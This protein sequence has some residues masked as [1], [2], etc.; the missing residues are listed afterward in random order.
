MTMAF[1]GKGL[2]WHPPNKAQTLCHVC[3][4][5]GC[6]P[7]VCNP[8][9]TQKVDDRLNKLYSRFNAGPRR[10]RQDSH[11]SRENSNSRSRSNNNTN[12]SRPNTS[13]SSNRTNNN[14]NNHRNNNNPSGSTSPSHKPHPVSSVPPTFPS[15]NPACTLPQHNYH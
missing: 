8:C 7:S 5:P 2:T 4:R 14:N 3:G 9:T 13:Q 15:D 12:T 6:S 1:R 11:Q 10:G